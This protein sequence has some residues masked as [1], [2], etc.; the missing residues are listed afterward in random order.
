MNK[1]DYVLNDMTV[2]TPRCSVSSVVVDYAFA[3]IPK[4]LVAQPLFEKPK[5]GWTEYMNRY[6]AVFDR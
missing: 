4:I 5:W 3:R 2:L 1:V 6:F